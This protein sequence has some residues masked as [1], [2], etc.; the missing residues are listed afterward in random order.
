MFVP[1]FIPSCFLKHVSFLEVSMHFHTHTLRVATWSHAGHVKKNAF[2]TPKQTPKN[3][4]ATKQNRPHKQSCGTP[5]IETPTQREKHE[6]S[7][8]TKNKKLNQQT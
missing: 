3:T 7:E 8:A 2:A 5:K 1:F 4:A 6:K